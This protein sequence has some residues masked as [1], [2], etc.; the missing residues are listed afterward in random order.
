MDDYETFP[1][2]PLTS[3]LDVIRLVRTQK[4]GVSGSKKCYF[5]WKFCLR[6]KW[7]IPY[8]LA[9][10]RYFTV[11]FAKLFKTTFSK[12]ICCWLFLR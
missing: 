6:I 1:E 3:V 12:N 4:Q 2:G 7:M 8:G 11:N 10:R 9:V 5:F